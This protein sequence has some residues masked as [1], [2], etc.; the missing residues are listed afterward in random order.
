MDTTRKLKTYSKFLKHLEE[1]TLENESFVK[2]PKKLL[3]D[4]CLTP[5]ERIT[6]MVLASHQYKSKSEIFPSRRRLAA[7]LGIKDIRQISK[8]TRSLQDKAYLAKEYDERSKK[9][10]YKLFFFAD[11]NDHL[12]SGFAVNEERVRSEYNHVVGTRPKDSG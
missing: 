9:A 12:Y 2:V 6:W 5:K 4:T 3:F 10:F 8:L 1:N 11:T 7:M